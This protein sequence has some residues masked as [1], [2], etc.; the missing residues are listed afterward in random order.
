M[1]GEQDELAGGQDLR[2][3]DR[4][5]SKGAVGRAGCGMREGQGG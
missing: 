4:K 2:W 3:A 1:E 5:G